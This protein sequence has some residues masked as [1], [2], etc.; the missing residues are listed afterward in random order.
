[1]RHFIYAKPQ[2][3]KNFQKIK[4]VNGGFYLEPN[5]MYATIFTDDPN[6]FP[7]LLRNGLVG[8]ALARLRKAFPLIEFEQRTA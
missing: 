2:G 8:D 1:M 6:D 4:L 7:E 3:E 5:A